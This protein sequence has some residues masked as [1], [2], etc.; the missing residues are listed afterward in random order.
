MKRIL[1][2]DY[3]TKRVGVAMSDP[4]GITAQPQA[5]FPVTEH[6]FDTI[7]AFIESQSVGKVVLGL[8]LTMKGT[9]SKMT[10]EV[11]A[12]AEKLQEFLQVPVELYDERCTSDSA[13]RA[14]IEGNVSRKRRKDLVDSI[15]ATILL[16]AY[17]QEHG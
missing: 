9:D 5:F 7:G 11:R 2:L 3:G 1:A 15:A 17:L 4:L 12:F 6:L 16:Q 8:P 14:L 10:I 13:N